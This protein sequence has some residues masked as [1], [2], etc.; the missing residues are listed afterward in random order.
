V[1]AIGQWPFVAVV[2]ASLAW[3]GVA[4]IVAAWP[5]VQVFRLMK[6]A[7]EQHGIAAVS[8][9]VADLI[10]RLAAV[11]GPPLILFILWRVGR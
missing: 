9:S 2:L 7:E 3:I 8:G 10:A 4:G 11:L 5:F 6:V 1:K